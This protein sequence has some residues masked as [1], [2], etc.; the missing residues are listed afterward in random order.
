M[1]LLLVVSCPESIRGKAGVNPLNKQ[2]NKHTK[3]TNFNE[4]KWNPE[5]LTLL[6]NTVSVL[7]I[8]NENYNYTIPVFP[9]WN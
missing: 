1:F 2:T 3:Q 8:F 5:I 6:S 4:L 7:L 9:I